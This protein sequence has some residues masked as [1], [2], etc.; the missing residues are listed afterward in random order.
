MGRLFEI[1]EQKISKT[2]LRGQKSNFNFQNRGYFGKKKSKSPLVAG[3]FFETTRE[4]KCPRLVLHVQCSSHKKKKR[5][6][7]KERE[8]ERKRPREE[9][10]KRVR[11]SKRKKQKKKSTL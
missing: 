7:K 8:K 4:A 2:F 10:R 1:F 11:K 6:K 9:E 3:T 5:K